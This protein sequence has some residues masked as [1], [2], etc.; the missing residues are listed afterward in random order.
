MRGDGRAPRLLLGQR[1]LHNEAFPAAAAAPRASVLLE[2]RAAHQGVG[3]R[4]AAGSDGAHEASQAFLQTQRKGL[5]CRHVLELSLPD[6][7]IPPKPAA[8]VAREAERKE[9]RQVCTGT[10]CSL[11][12]PRATS[13]D[14]P[15][16][17][18]AT[19]TGGP[20]GRSRAGPHQLPT[21]SWAQQPGKRALRC[22]GSDRTTRGPRPLS[23][24][25]AQPSP[26]PLCGQPPARITDALALVPTEDVAESWCS[27]PRLNMPAF[28]RQTPGHPGT[29]QAAEGPQ[30][31]R[32]VGTVAVACLQDREQGLG[33][34]QGWR[35]QKPGGASRRQQ[36]EEPAPAT[37][38]HQEV[39]LHPARRKQTTERY[40]AKKEPH[41]RRRRL[42]AAGGPSL[43]IPEQPPALL[44]R[45]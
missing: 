4:L 10:T 8:H 28:P 45:Q 1:G 41:G 35:P 19:K 37:P 12:S 9:D 25:H 15:R 13:M 26:R 17:Y 44:S 34:G 43:W 16:S 40:V 7:G 24:R 20:G 14:P 38:A 32:P 18:G 42:R 2:D 6:I 36:G 30:L 22:S 27:P 33:P 23:I 3:R 5:A 31:A 29:E 11:F 21:Q 39:R